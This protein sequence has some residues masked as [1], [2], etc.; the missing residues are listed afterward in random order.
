MSTIT[1]IQTKEELTTF[2]E[3]SKK[4]VIY[5]TIFEAK[6][7]FTKNIL[8]GAYKQFEEF[9]EKSTDSDLKFAAI[10]LLKSEKLAEELKVTALSSFHGYVDN[11]KFVSKTG[12]TKDVN[13]DLPELIS[14]VNDPA[15][16]LPYKAKDEADFDKILKENELVVCDFTASW[17]G[18]CQQ[19]GPKFKALAKKQQKNG[20]LLKTSEKTIKFIKVEQTENKELVTR[21]GV[22]CYPSFYFYKDG[23]K[24]DKLEGADEEK[25]ILQS[26]KLIDEN[27]EEIHY[28]VQLDTEQ[29]FDDCLKTHE[30]V[31]VDFTATWCPPCKMI[32]PIYEELAEQHKDNEKVK[33]VKIDVDENNAISSRYSVRSMPTFKVFKNEKEQ[34]DSG[35]GG[36]SVDKLKKMVEDFTKDL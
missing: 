24:V 16:I 7:E 34:T 25:L 12:Q 4:Q 13:A 28:A 26:K 2:Q 30:I 18:P 3:S 1:K 33:F 10:D 15:S 23:K 8:A 17:C 22:S 21:E 29:E 32:K 11:D 5:F 19:I 31:F 14:E 35:F 36:A 6:D 27:Y 9:V 20:K